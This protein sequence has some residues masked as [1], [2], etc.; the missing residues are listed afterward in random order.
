ME[1]FIKRTLPLLLT[2]PFYLFPLGEKP[3]VI[4]GQATFEKPNPTTE[5]VRVTDKT[6]I[7]YQRFNLAQNEKTEFVQPSHKSTLLCRIKG[8]DPSVLR[9]RLE[10]N[11]K[12][13]FINPNGII[14]SETA[15][16]NVGTLIASTLDI[17]NTDFL[18]GRFRF[19][20]SPEAYKSSILNKGHIQAAHDVVFMAPQ[21]R[22]QGIISAHAG[23]VALLGGEMMTLDFDEDNLISFAIEAPLKQGFIEQAGQILG[24]R[25]WMNISTASQLIKSVLNVNDLVEA[26]RIEIENGV[27]RLTPKNKTEA[28]EMRLAGRSLEIAGE[29]KI[30]GF[31]ELTAEQ[32]IRWLRSKSSRRLETQSP[33]CPY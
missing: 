15:H 23:K 27:I 16:V 24:S 13:L 18:N 33:S 26:G 2:A 4:S 32:E 7:Q 1:S 21:I 29:L 19:N 8:R 20:L 5:V 9:G 11:G 22:N 25:V 3:E 6:I 12:L 31:C 30:P 17:E 14:F 10:A 28:G